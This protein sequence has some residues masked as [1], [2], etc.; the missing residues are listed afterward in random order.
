[1]S[2]TLMRGDGPRGKIENETLNTLNNRGM[3]FGN[4]YGHGRAASL[5]GVFAMLIDA[6]VFGRPKP[7]TVT[8]PYF[9]GLRPKGRNAGC[10]RGM[11]GIVL[12]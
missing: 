4:S 8:V 12:D 2:F 7:A 1:M 11:R 3:N 5:R 9:E 10:G 6:G